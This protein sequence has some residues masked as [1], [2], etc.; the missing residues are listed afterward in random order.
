MATKGIEFFCY[1]IMQA[2]LGKINWK[3]IMIEPFE[4]AEE[5]LK[6]N[7]YGPKRIIEALTPLLQLSDSPRIVNVSSSAGKLKVQR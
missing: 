5:C 7:Y 6:V 1:S 4:Q 2:G 3:E